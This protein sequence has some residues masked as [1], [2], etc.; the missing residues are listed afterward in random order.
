[1]RALAT[2]PNSHSLTRNQVAAVF[3]GLP[4][5]AGPRRRQRNGIILPDGTYTLKLSALDAQGKASPGPNDP[6]AT[7]I[8]DTTPPTFSVLIDDS[9]PFKIVNDIVPKIKFVLKDNLS[10]FSQDTVINSLKFST[11]GDGVTPAL[12]SSAYKLDV[13]SETVTYEVPFRE[14]SI[15]YPGDQSFNVVIEDAAGNRASGTTAFTVG[16][17]SLYSGTPVNHAYR[18]ASTEPDYI[19]YPIPASVDTSGKTIIKIKEPIF[20]RNYYDPSLAPPKVWGYLI[21]GGGAAGIVTFVFLDDVRDN[22]R[23]FITQDALFTI[24]TEDFG[25]VKMYKDPK[26]LDNDRIHFLKHPEMTTDIVEA[27]IDAIN[28]PRGN[29]EIWRNPTLPKHLSDDILAVY[30]N[31]DYIYKVIIQRQ[32][33]GFY[34]VKTAYGA[35][36]GSNSGKFNPLPLTPQDLLNLTP[37]ALKTFHIIQWSSVA[38][39]VLKYNMAM[40]G[41]RG[42]NKGTKYISGNNNSPTYSRHIEFEIPYDGIK[43]YDFSPDGLSAVYRPRHYIYQTAL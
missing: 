8:I 4:L 1:M 43:P 36:I 9:A 18:L 34:F 13:A 20:L 40:N 26:I 15:L 41:D 22:V 19:D 11:R 3:A 35:G 6:T 32:G 14:D 28:R 27:A 42:P 12:D 2:Q 29:I 7:V 17:H 31:L 24:Q 38:R 16:A 30:K 37:A 23:D 10:Q 21:K 39:D 33:N 25:R 5:R